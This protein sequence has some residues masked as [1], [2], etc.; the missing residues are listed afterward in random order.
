MSESRN[1]RYTKENDVAKWEPKEAELGVFFRLKVGG[2][3]G[4]MYSTRAAADSAVSDTAAFSTEI[5][6]TFDYFSSKI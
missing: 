1:F 3:R 5:I 4:L 2:F 6:V